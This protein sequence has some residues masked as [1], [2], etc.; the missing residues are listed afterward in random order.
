MR[1]R[2]T[3]SWASL[4]L[5]S[6]VS[7]NGCADESRGFQI[8]DVTTGTTRGP[9]GSSFSLAP[10]SGPD[11]VTVQVEAVDMPSPDPAW[12]VL[13]PMVRVG[14]VEAPLGVTLE[15]ALNVP[16]SALPAGAQLEDV[17]LLTSPMGQAR[18]SVVD[19]PTSASGQLGTSIDGA[20]DLVLAVPRP[21]FACDERARTYLAAHAGGVSVFVLGN[22]GAA[23]DGLDCFLHAELELDGSVVL[24][25]GT[26]QASGSPLAGQATVH[27][28]Y[29]FVNER[30]R[31]VFEITGA[32]REDLPPAGV[33]VPLGLATASGDLEVTL[34]GDV[35][36][37]SPLEGLA[38]SA[39]VGSIES[40]QLLATVVQVAQRLAEVRLDGFGS[41]RSTTYL[42]PHSL[43]GANSGTGAY[44]W[45][46]LLRPTTHLWFDGFSDL[47]G[48]VLDGEVVD[49][50]NTASVG[51]R[52]GTVSFGLRGS[53]G[54]QTT[55]SIDYLGVSIEKWL[56]D[57][58]TGTARVA[59]SAWSSATYT[60][61]ASTLAT[62]DL[63]PAFAIP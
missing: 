30:E 39:S 24:D 16:Q 54:T 44:A 22:A 40:A 32:I 3:R 27:A 19:A 14:L 33:V 9:A 23:S 26:Y 38:Q 36:A 48:L 8:V 55:G 1:A 62:Y 15:A 45:E 10:G 12:V 42:A 18:F 7:A 35:T 5:I 13:G 60:V 57:G 34:G 52:K 47:P 31:S 46:S 49:E 51:A 37:V 25:R 43:F 2:F 50:V 41:A 29:S 63:R 4:V 61:A 21:G 58:A 20:T 53:D 56:V 11:A 17:R 59:S 28:R 6:A